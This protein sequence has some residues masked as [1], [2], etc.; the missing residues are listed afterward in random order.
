[1]CHKPFINNNQIEQFNKNSDSNG[2]L[3]YFDCQECLNKLIPVS[4]DDEYTRMVDD[5]IKTSNS[6]KTHQQQQ[7][8]QQQTHKFFKREIQ[9]VF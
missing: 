7:S 9:K 3:L 8:N 2:M 5:V 1:M 4:N 6:I